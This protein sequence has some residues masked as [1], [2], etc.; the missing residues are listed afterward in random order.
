MASRDDYTV[1]WI[2]ALPL[3]MAAAKAVLDHIHAD[4]PADPSLNDSNSYVLGSLNEHNIVVACLPFGVYGTTSAATV[5]AQML[6][7]FKSIRFSL[8]VGIG[9]GVPST[10]EDVRLG[11]IVVS[12]PSAARPGIIQYDFGKKTGEGQFTST[13]AL[14]KPSTLLLTAAGKVETNNILGESQIPRYIH[15]IVEKDP[16]VFAH[17]GSE[18]DALFDSNYDHVAALGDDGTCTQCDPARLLHRPPRGSQNPKVHYG[19]V[20]SGNQVMRHGGTRD[21]L[22]R[23]HGILCFEMEAAGLMDI[24]QCLVIRGICD[25][26]DSHKTKVWQGYA[27]GAAAAYAKELLSL[28]PP[29]PKPPPLASITDST[30]AGVLDALLLTRPEVDRSSL[31]ALKGRRVAGTCEWLLRHDHY[32]EWLKG[33]DPPLLWISGGPGKGKTILSIYITEELESVV[34][35]AQGVLLYYFCSNRDKNRNSAMTIMRGLLH[36]WLSLHP[37]LAQHIQNFFDGSETTKYTISNFICLWKLFLSLLNHTD[38]PQ[39]VCVLD[40]LDECEEESLK[41]LLDVLSEYFSNSEAKPNTYLKVILLSRPQPG[42]LKSKLHRFPRIKLDDSDVEIQKDVEKYISAKVAELAAENILSEDRLRQ[43]SQTLMAS[44]EGTFLWVG[45]VADELKGKNWLQINHILRGVPKDLVGVYQRLLQQVEDKENLVPILEWIVLAARPMTVDEL[46]MAAEIKA[47][48]AL[49]PAEILKDRLASCGLL[50]K[51]DGDVV[52]LVH[53][54][55]RE[56]FQSDQINIDGIN[57][58]HMNHKSHKTLMRTCLGLIEG[59]YKS[60]GSISNASLHNSLLTYASLYWPEYFRQAFDSV[61]AQLEFSSQFFRAESPVRE[62]WWKFYWDREQYGGAPPSFTLLHLAAYFGNLAWAKMLLKHSAAAGIPFRRRTSR[63]D[64]YGRTPLFWAATRGHRDVVELLLEHGAN[65]NSKDR[66]KLTALHIAVTGEHKDVVSLLLDRS[67]RIEAKGSYGDTPLIRAIQASSKDIVKLLLEHG[68]RVDK[69]PTPPGVA[70]LKGP[71]DPLE[72][73]VKQLLELQEMLF[74]ARYDNQSRL[75]DLTLKILTVSL[76]YKPI[77]RLVALYVRHWS[78]GRWEVLQDLVKNNETARL[79]K[80]AQSFS[81]FG[82]QLVEARNPRDLEAM[83]GLSVRVFEVVSTADLEALLVIGVLV[84]SSVML[85]SAKSRWREGVDISGRTFSQFAS[86]AYHRGTEES[87]DYG[88]R[89]FLIDLD[90]SIRAGNRADTVDRVVVMFSTH[91][92]ILASKDP[93]PIEYFSTVL[94]EYFEH[95][96]GGSYEEQLFSDASE[97]CANELAAINKCQDSR[98]LFLLLSAIFKIAQHSREKGQDRLLNIPPA[99]CLILCQDDPDS[100]RWL[101]GEGIPETVSVLIPRQQ[102]GLSRKRAFKA[103][104]ECLIIGKQF[105]LS[106][107]MGVRETVKR[108]LELIDGVDGMLDQLLST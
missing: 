61:E 17:P 40:G 97:A 103:L 25:Y 34:D 28:M 69:L 44:A 16:L 58:F 67:A 27:A 68:A 35:D 100:H 78:V 41:Q 53:E 13:G 49:T 79:R 70:A 30:V 75:V 65:I 11:D 74:T 81:S 95:Y 21:K 20:A 71:M 48:H 26:A 8:M 33:T 83:T 66:D 91:L 98:R 77:F 80:W 2:C 86:L 85:A 106:L 14:N 24:A 1:G 72:E 6:A 9:G 108:N 22:A 29:A 107:S 90:A 42:P 3:E 82:N 87:L 105:G 5:A 92:A 60:P 51:I 50:V 45:F 84:G 32:Q 102:Q 89:Q 31:I 52:N 62:D 38:A 37:H 23:E 56:F 101:I 39:V 18:Q 93:R 55:A 76:R 36:Q 47:F 73:R 63:K 57:V 46:A 104:V 94:T 96:I 15:K 54:S 12:R 59:S 19:L 88:V 10:K 43:V 99:S 4:L 7:S 64:S